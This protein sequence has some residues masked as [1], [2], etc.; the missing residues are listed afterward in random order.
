MSNACSVWVS[1]ACR[2]W[3]SKALGCVGVEGL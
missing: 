2:V 3:V 1:N